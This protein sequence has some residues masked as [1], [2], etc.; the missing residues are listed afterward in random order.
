M[1][2]TESL[3]KI[4]LSKKYTQEK[5]ATILQTTQQQYS[6]YERGEQEIPIRHIVTLARQY[7]VTTNYLLGIDTYMTPEEDKSKF[8]QLYE[9]IENTI[10]EAVIQ[11]FISDDAAEVIM[12]NINTFKT[13]IENSPCRG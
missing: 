12:E 3:R 5:I 7:N 1:E 2:I 4:R 11:K 9:K 6:K 13:E 10:D 8:Q